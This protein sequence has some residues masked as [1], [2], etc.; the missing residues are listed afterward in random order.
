MS[1]KKVLCVIGMMFT[2]ATMAHAVDISI[3]LS[4]GVGPT[5]FRGGSDLMSTFDTYKEEYGSY[6]GVDVAYRFQID[7]LAEFAQFFALETGFGF[8]HNI[9]S[10]E[11][12]SYSRF[13]GNGEGN[14]YGILEETVQ[15]AQL[16]IPL[17]LRLQKAWGG[18]SAWMVSYLSAGIRLG[19]P[20]ADFW[21]FEY[22]V[23]SSTASSFDFSYQGTSSSVVWD[24]CIAIGH[25]FQL[26]ESNYL[27][28]RIGYDINLSNPSTEYIETKDG[29]IYAPAEYDPENMGKM[30]MDSLLFSIT[31]RYSFEGKMY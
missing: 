6:S 28:L 4:A 1:F 19:I 21:K 15:R 16:N 3:G 22:S 12:A 27:G 10:F 9:K 7:I 5:F 2:L 14:G 30:F 31:W 18:G 11:T 20:V 29:V 17:M 23:V 26:S 25:E 24:F 13:A 8:S